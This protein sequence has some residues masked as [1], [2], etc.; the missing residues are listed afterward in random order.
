MRGPERVPAVARPY[1]NN[2][3]YNVLIRVGLYVREGAWEDPSILL[4][5]L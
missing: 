4:L 3:Q 2:A 5:C 1:F